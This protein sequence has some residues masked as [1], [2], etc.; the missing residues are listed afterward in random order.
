[1]TSWWD[2]L[3]WNNETDTLGDR[4]I[5]KAA[6]PN[7][8]KALFFEEDRCRRG[9]AAYEA[10]VRRVVSKFRFDFGR[11]AD[12]ER[13]R[14]VI[15]ELEQRSSLFRRIW[16]SPDVSRCLDG[17]IHLSCVGGLSFEVSSHVPEDGS[18]LRILIFRPYD[19]HP[20]RASLSHP[21]RHKGIGRPR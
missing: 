2:V 3:A 21:Q 16:R 17:P 1:M 9:L 8:L 7:L 19:E 6:S 4:S 10:L 20:S 15:D 18:A 5:V 13:F 11:S 12:D 14:A